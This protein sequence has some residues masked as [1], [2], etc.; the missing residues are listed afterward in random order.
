MRSNNRKPIFTSGS[1]LRTSPGSV[2]K[3]AL[4]ILLMCAANAGLGYVIYEYTG[5]PFE[6]IIDNDPPAGSYTTDMRITGSF[7]FE[8]EDFFPP[9]L[10]SYSFSDGRRTLTDTNSRLGTI[11][12]QVDD[13]GNDFWL[14]ELSLLEPE[15]ATGPYVIQSYNSPEIPGAPFYLVSDILGGGGDSARVTNNPGT[16]I[17]REEDVS[18]PEPSTFLIFGPALLGVMGLQWLRRH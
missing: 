5:N 1:V 4:G 13:E 6:E 12:F 3:L 9:L 11:G 17:I 8:S 15:P 18:V 2:L 10:T 7:Y 14:L 16:W